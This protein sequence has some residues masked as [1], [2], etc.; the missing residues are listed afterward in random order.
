MPGAGGGADLSPCRGAE[1]TARE[2]LELVLERNP[3][4]AARAKRLDL[5]SR[6]RSPS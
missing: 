4:Q 6:P 3:F 2:L 1:T 5:G